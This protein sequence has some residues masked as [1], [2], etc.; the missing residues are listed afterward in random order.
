MS[1]PIAFIFVFV[2]GKKP[3]EKK[4]EK[5]RS[6]IA[7]WSHGGILNMQVPDEYVTYSTTR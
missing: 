4:K 1:I 6:E 3:R 5:E 2:K 7:N